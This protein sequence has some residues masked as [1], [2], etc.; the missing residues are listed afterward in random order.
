[1]PSNHSDQPGQD[2]G[3]FDRPESRPAV[4]GIVHAYQKF[5]P[6]SFPPPQQEPPDLVSPSFEQALM[7][8]EFRDLTEEELARA[9][10]LDP[11]QI[12]GLGPSIDFLQAMLEERKRKILETYEARSVVRKAAKAFDKSTKDVQV[13][14]KMRD[15]F[16]TAIKYQQP[17]LMESLWYRAESLGGNLPTQLLRIH[18]AMVD[19]HEIEE[20]ASRYEFTGNESMSVPQALEIKKELEAIDELLEQLKKAAETAQIGLI[21]MDQ[22]SQ[23][24]AAQDIEQLEDMRRQVENLIREQAE[25]QGLQR[26]SQG[27]FRLTPQAYKIF[28]GRLLEKIFSDLAPSKSGR[29][30]GNVIGQGAVEL[31]T[32][33][34]YEFGDSLANMDLTQTVINSLVRQGDSR[35]LR[36]HSD[37]IEIHKTR[38]HPKCATCVIMDMSGSMR[39]DGQY[40]NVK[41][42]A[43][44]LQGLIQSEYPG[45]FL[46]FI[47]MYTFAKLRAPGEII[48]LM[49]K[50]VSIHDPWVR[51]KA[52]LSDPEMSEHQI[53]QHFTNIQR[54]LQLARQ[55]LANCD[56]PNRQVVL[57]TDGLPTAHCEGEWLYM[58]YP[59]DPTTEQAT[60]REAM[61]C[62][63][64][65]IT[66]NIFLIPSWS[67]NEE[68][69]RFAN[70]LA[71]STNGRVFFTSGNNLDRFVL[72]DYV[73]NKR[74]IIQ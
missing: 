28:Q 37:D 44:A 63:K 27:H 40:I 11:S 14:K 60:M 2:S 53:H 64:E 7:Y 52:D 61:L 49:P 43:L 15:A 34:P 55:S 23:F 66:I 1:M 68:D 54:S 35:P 31:Q 17:Y 21:D 71:Q 26:D 20:M 10:R 33:K 8:G 25:R 48:H 16:S 19:K 74:E 29:H 56:T 3:P 4:G 24:A 12:K 62:A 45:D 65:G 73:Q 50:P 13:P 30:Q 9:V 47:E 59:P 67:Q 72:W 41:R 51:L 58:L 5:D 46:R 42:M 18:T 57:I 32:T 70:R 39:Y 36:L 6:R 22:L 69:I 38:N